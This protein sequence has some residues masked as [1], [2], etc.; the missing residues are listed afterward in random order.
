M[1]QNSTSDAPAP[2][3]S[4]ETRASIP[5]AQQWFGQFGWQPP[6]WLQ[7]RL[8]VIRRRPRDYLGG[9]VALLVLAATGYWWATRPTPVLPDALQVEVHAPVLTDYT[10]TPIRVDIL[11]LNFSGSAAP[12][13]A[14][15]AAPKGVR[16]QPELP[17]VWLWS[18]DHTLEFTPA[19]D[20]PV[21][22]TFQVLIDTDTAIAPKV[23]L[24][25]DM[26]EFQTP[27]F[28]VML[29]RNEF[30]QDP[31]DPTLKKAVY[32]LGFSHPVDAAQVERRIE[33]SFTDGA[34]TKLAVPSHTVSYDERRL[35]AWVHSQPLQIPEN[36]GT[37]ELTLAAGVAS[38]LGGEGS[39][40]ALTGKV[41]LPSLYSVAINA[42]TLTLAENERFEPEQ[43]LVLEFNN[44]MRDT[45]V[46]GAVQLWLLPAKN[47]KIAADQQPV[48]YAWDKS[49]VGE[50]VLKQ[51]QLVPI[52]AMPAEREYV[53]THSFKYHAPPGRVLYVRV[54]KG[55]KAFGGFLLSAVYSSVAQ[56]PQYPQLLRFVGE[57]ALLSLQGERRVSIVSR[58]V[59]AARLEV[60][61]VLPEQLHH[62]AFANEGSYDKPRLWGIEANSLVDRVE[63][64]LRLP[65]DDPAKAHY[66]GVDLGQFLSASRRGVFMLS[67][68]T[69]SEA[70]EARS[71]QATLAEDAG[72]ERDSRLIVLT[73][74]GIVAKK[75][76]DGSR[77]V[78]VQSLD[79]GTPVAGARVRAIARNGE[80]LAEVDSDAEG[81]ARLP[82]L[83]D[84]KREKQAVMLTISQGKD[85]SF[86]PIDDSG[87]SLDYSRFDIGGE[88]NEIEAG[89]LNAFLFSDRGLY[90]PGDTI[91]LGIIVRPA[92]WKQPLMGL[93]LE[94]VL[95]DPRGTLVRRERLKLSESGFESFSHTPQDSAPS[96]TWQASLY[97]I[98]KDNERTAIGETSVQVREFAP[99]T[100]RVRAQLSMEN[101][102]G[103]V[104][105]TNLTATVIAENLFGTPAQQRRVEA[106]LVLRPAFPSFPAY[107]DYRFYDPL[108]A[109]DGY[110]ESLSD[111]ITDATG[112]AVFKLA[113]EKYTKATY[114]LNFLARAFE[115]GSGRNVAAQT[116]MLVSNND[117]L[118]GIKAV[119]AL[120]YVKRNAPRAVQLLAIGPDGKPLAVKGLRAAVVERRYVSVL[121]RENSGLYRYV[122]RERR[123]PL[124]EQTLKPIAGAQAFA[125]PTHTPGDFLLEVRTTDGTVLNQIDYSVA[126]AANV[127]RSLERNA[128]LALKLSKPSY[129][130]GESIEISVRAPY[131]GSGLI[132]IERD[133]VVAHAWFRADTTSSVQH[134]QVPADFE[135]NGYVNVQFLRDPSSDEIFMSP[136]SYGVAPF[137]VDRS[138]RT[139]P[140]QLSVPKVVKP[141]AA[142]PVDVS[143]EGKARVVV[144]AVDEGILQV[145]RY[146]V[147]DPLDHFFRKKM[148]QV[149]TAQILDLLLPEFSRLTALTAPGGDGEGSLAKNLNPFKRKSEKPA[150]WWSGIFDVDGHKQVKFTLP[151]H[152]NGQVRL[153]AVAVTPQRIGLAQTQMLVR[154]D[155]VL[156]PTVPT[157]VAP[158]DEFELP[159]GI[160]NTIEGAK[161]AVLVKASLALPASLTLVGTAPPPLSLAPGAEGTVR[162]RLRAGSVL[163]AAP[164]VVRV[165]SGAYRG[166]RRIELS[167]RPA[168]ALRQ[169][170]RVA[171]AEQ[172]VALEGLRSMFNQRATRQ[173]SASVSPLVALDGLTA[174]LSDYPHM[175]TEQLLSQAMPA[176]VIGAHPEFGRILRDQKSNPRLN[177][178]DALR[179]RQNS[180]GGLGDWTATP[181]A[182]PFVSGYAALYLLESRERGNAVPEDMLKSLNGYLE[183]LAADASQHDLPTLRARALAVYL[184]I[185]QGHTASNLLSAVHEQLKRDQPK[186]WQNDVASLLLAASY[187]LLQKDLPAR[188]LALK[189]LTRAN[190]PAAPVAN[191]YAS[192]Y[193]NGIDQAWTVYLLNRNFPTLAKQLKPA[194]T[195]RLLDPLR[196]NSYNTLSSALTVLALDA[197]ATARSNT[198]LPTLQAAGKDGKP[199]QIGTALGQIVRGNFT[200]SDARLW[201]SPADKTPVWYLLNQSGFDRKPPVATQS[202]G[203]EVVRDYLGD[204]GKPVR[205][206][207]LGSEVTV[208]LR[209]RALGAPA[210]GNIA[211]LD[212]LPGGFEPVLQ[213]PPAASDDSGADADADAESGDEDDDASESG[214]NAAPAPTL[215]L[216]GSSFR[217]MHLEQREDRIVF[218]GNVGGQVTELRYR[219]RANNIGTFAVPPIY[220]ESM[221]ERSVYAQGGS[222]GTLQVTAPKP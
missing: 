141:G 202:H 168:I 116:S 114:Q 23:H 208:R 84:F 77:D 204:D 153:V 59:H 143:T 56:V 207:A 117:Y 118:I 82:A 79:Q 61:R 49:E 62:L 64:R 91:N 22:K 167:L 76:L 125:L 194:A 121:T 63:K 196:T 126:G 50:D 188:E 128:E 209:V 80:T 29:A 221:Y 38:T 175:C 57:G 40:E 97:L 210:R 33:L 72:D 193:D 52:T 32:E 122:S 135:G 119:D 46:A 58:N 12:I 13:S 66:E 43:V 51:A 140:L 88:P 93:P 184:L 9:F 15:D 201:V 156:T 1:Q 108:R 146:R 105:P 166:Q 149:D 112:K 96:G 200:G 102:Q 71:P 160:A 181:E 48:I 164:I 89:A 177:L 212:L 197:Y 26:F 69:L 37:V 53:E 110:D 154:G 17:G 134:I 11:R 129:R 179:S 158:G 83:D 19:G 99:D 217:P 163:G 172:R 170:L 70:D 60:A 100:M 180:E 35:K 27:P 65:A 185:R 54:D 169:D 183:T 94:L 95:S 123:Y 137:T 138:A 161:N 101:P 150:V 14:V 18:S 124:Q 68:R 7:R 173:L 55:L 47:P 20:W 195:E 30:Y 219:V 139:Q 155:F 148:L 218:Y 104:K 186:T 45:E 152:F 10:Q 73:D 220:A 131:P 5:L 25:Q 86:L 191:T 109:K 203:L 85:F 4:V 147:G 44:A 6:A 211:I 133:R 213:T 87:R 120:N 21:G 222:A 2:S 106:T 142:I 75:G 145:A 16:L 182:D 198:P 132:T 28:Q 171:H 127:S 159:V 3:E 165:Q 67:L 36:G 174:Y 162:F 216:P 190:L 41:V 78:F 107:P 39:A 199:R 144:F 34:G 214:S 136:L 81:R 206:L 31:L 42:S 113:L 130:P 178:I 192:Y 205:T 98:G 187:Q 189:A 103:W 215:A 115:P 90:R 8:A 111:Q 151:D 92:D 157:H 24:A 176:L 74:L